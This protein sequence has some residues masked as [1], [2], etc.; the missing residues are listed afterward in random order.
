MIRK[1]KVLGLALVETVVVHPEYSGCKAF[2][3]LNAT[4]TTTGC[5]YTLNAAGT[6]EAT[7]GVQG[8]LSGISYENLTGL[9]RR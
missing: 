9:P 6:C 3:F 1:F 2:T 8:P 5:T 7:V 4:V